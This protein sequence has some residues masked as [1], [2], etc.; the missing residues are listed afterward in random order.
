MKLTENFNKSEFES[1]DGATM[2]PVVLTRIKILA[3]N[4]Q[5]LRN[6]VNKSI[7]ITSGYRSPA[8]NRRVGGAPSSKHVLGE[9][10]DFKIPGMTPREVYLTILELQRQGKM[11]KGG[12]HAYSTWVHYDIRGYNARW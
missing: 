12:L 7:I 6:H 11:L 4:L 10:A 1:K 8:H 5:V 9:A 3:E 2:P